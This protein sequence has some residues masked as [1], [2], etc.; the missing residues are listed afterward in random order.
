MKKIFLLLLCFVLVGCGIIFGGCVVGKYNLAT[1]NGLECLNKNKFDHA[2]KWFNKAIQ[3]DSSIPLAYEWRGEAYYRK[4]DFNAAIQDFNIAIKMNNNDA[5]A[6]LLRGSVYAEINNSEQ[7]F[8]DFSKVIE[9][10]QYNYEAYYKRALLYL[11]LKK[12]DD[13]EK[14]IEAIEWIKTQ[15]RDGDFLQNA[16]AVLRNALDKANEEE[17]MFQESKGGQA[18]WKVFCNISP[19]KFLGLFYGSVPTS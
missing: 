1:S 4:G 2:I 18:D 11:K 8:S 19:K 7:A 17:K 14:D 3:Y 13:A 15:L 16:I 12:F 5:S 6:Y 9:I 10:N